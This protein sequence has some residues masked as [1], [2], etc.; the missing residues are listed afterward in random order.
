MRL[1]SVAG[2]MRKLNDGKGVGMT[3]GWTARTRGHR[4]RSVTHKSVSTPAVSQATDA[5]SPRSSGPRPNSRSHRPSPPSFSNPRPQDVDI[6][7]RRKRAVLATLRTPTTCQGL[8][9]VSTTSYDTGTT[10][11]AQH[12]RSPPTPR[13]SGVDLSCRRKTAVHL[14][15]A[16]ANES[17][18]DDLAS[19]ALHTHARRPPAPPPPPPCSPD[20]FLSSRRKNGSSHG[21]IRRTCPAPREDY[22]LLPRRVQRRRTQSLKAIGRRDRPRCAISSPGETACFM[23]L[24]DK[25]A[26]RGESIAGVDQGSTTEDAHKVWKGAVQ[27]CVVNARFC[28]RAPRRPR[29]LIVSRGP[30][31]AVLRCVSDAPMSLTP[32]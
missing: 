16:P 6:G 26:P 29:K 9:D 15:T 10:A 18:V 17:S 23:A 24:F 32:R 21:T 8:E 1:D 19:T 31:T 13:S 7:S 2:G 14:L 5:Y 4:R 11:S 25:S 3:A 28:P 12:R 22:L 27:R 30:R 20:A